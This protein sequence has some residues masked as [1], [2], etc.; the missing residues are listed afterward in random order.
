[1]WV[2]SD[3][4]RIVNR[5]TMVGP[6][7][8]TQMSDTPRSTDPKTGKSADDTSWTSAEGAGD[9]GRDR[10]KEWLTQLQAMI[11]NVA[12]HA[13]PVAREIGAKA[14]ELAALAGTKAGPI[15]H[16]AAE[17]TAAA[18][19][20]V[21]ERGREVAADLRRDATTNGQGT[22]TTRSGTAIAAPEKTTGTA[23]TADTSPE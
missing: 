23:D 3:S 17:V 5:A 4:R 9:S 16:K 1:M 6:N 21:A 8:E 12:T 18:G 7:K 11:D 22:G 10:A 14:A 15:A 2:A 13:A 19:E 20:K